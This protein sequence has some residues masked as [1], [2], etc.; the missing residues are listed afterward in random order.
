MKPIGAE[1]RRL[2]AAMDMNL[3]E[4]GRLVGI[5]W[6]TVQA[7]ETGRAVP[8]ADRLL[9]IMHATRRVDEPFRVAHVVR[10][11]ARAAA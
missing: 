8:P 7:Y 2:R 9:A 3:A 4:F 10:A 6:Q 1:I 5:P 11:V